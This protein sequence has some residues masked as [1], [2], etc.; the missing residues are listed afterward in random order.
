VQTS[1]LEILD[2]RSSNHA[3][4]RRK[5]GPRLCDRFREAHET[6]SVSPMEMVLSLMEMAL[7]PMEMAPKSF[8][9]GVQGMIPQEHLLS[10]SDGGG[11]LMRISGALTFWMT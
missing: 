1:L 11:R 7:S 10:E 3:V 8:K 9:C 2:P 6:T 5:A 4:A